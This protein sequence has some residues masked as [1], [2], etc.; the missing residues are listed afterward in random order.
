MF[1]F[2]CY[3]SKGCANVCDATFEVQGSRKLAKM[4]SILTLWHAIIYTVNGIWMLWCVYLSVSQLAENRQFENEK[5]NEM[6]GLSSYLLRA[7]LFVLNIHYALDVYCCPH[8][9]YSYK[10]NVQRDLDLTVQFP[11]QQQYMTMPWQCLHHY[12]ISHNRRFDDGIDFS[13][14][15]DS[16]RRQ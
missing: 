11:H 14:A 1:A 16:L 6:V 3:D 5:K 10:L 4:G 7:Q 15:N 12:R 8:P 13:S 2:N 9:G